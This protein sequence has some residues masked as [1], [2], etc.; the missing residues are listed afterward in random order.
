MAAALE[1]AAGALPAWKANLPGDVMASELCEDNGPRRAHVCT[2][3]PVALH[4][5]AL[6]A[7]AA[8]HGGRRHIRP[9]GASCGLSEALGAAFLVDRRSVQRSHD[10]LLVK[11]GPAGPLTSILLDITGLGD[12][13]AICGCHLSPRGALVHSVSG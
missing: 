2:E 7:V 5:E 9:F 12:T 13:R 3:G 4:C 1:A 6:E 11:A 8:P 10:F